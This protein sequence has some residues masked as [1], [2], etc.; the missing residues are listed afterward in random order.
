MSE[1]KR[2]GLPYAFVICLC[3]ILSM[4]CVGAVAGSITA[5][6]PYIIEYG[7]LTQTQ[8]SSIFTIVCLVSLIVPPFCW[9]RTTADFLTAQVWRWHWQVRRWT[10]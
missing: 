3:G 10:T 2:T 8:G 7:G 9:S 6:L 5:Y 1:T 4:F